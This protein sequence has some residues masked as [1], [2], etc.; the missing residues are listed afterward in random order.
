MSNSYILD[1]C[2]FYPHLL[3]CRWAMVASTHLDTSFIFFFVELSRMQTFTGNPQ[4]RQSTP[5]LLRNIAG[6][7]P[8]WTFSW[9]GNP[10]DSHCTAR[11][12]FYY[13][14]Y[15]QYIKLSLKNHESSQLLQTG[16]LGV[17]SQATKRWFLNGRHN[18]E[19]IKAILQTWHFLSFRSC[20]TSWRNWSWINRDSNE[21][22][23]QVQRALVRQRVV[24]VQDLQLFPH[25]FFFNIYGT[26]TSA[27]WLTGWLSSQQ[28]SGL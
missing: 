20:L 25:N 21:R 15:R 3:P 1:C 19:S 11:T 22:S 2:L 5:G 14:I 23:V 26:H 10:N 28:V 9:V 24:T 7:R 8:S 4:C 17:H 18:R 27:C 6:T 16:P 12:C 13:Y